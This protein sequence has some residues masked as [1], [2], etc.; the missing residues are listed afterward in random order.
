MA[1]E[2]KPRPQVSAD[3]RRRLLMEA[4]MRVMKRDGIAAASTRAICLEADMPHGAFHYCFRS[5]HELFASLLEE[6]FN[7]PLETAWQQLDPGTDPEAGLRNLFREYWSGLEPDPEQQLVLSE[8]TNYALRDASLRGLP[9]WEHES[10]RAKIATHLAQFCDQ[11]DVEFA[12]PIA[13][14]AEMLLAALSGVTSSWL[15]H[16][17]SAIALASLDRFARVFASYAEPRQGG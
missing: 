4:A 5:K 9:E 14:L 17:D 10:Y 15:A 1:E 6:D 8:L 11:L 12:L 7:A 13:E 2:K 16:R 3:V